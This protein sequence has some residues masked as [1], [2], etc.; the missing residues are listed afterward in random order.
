MISKL[1]TSPMDMMDS[2]EA[3]VN[4]GEAENGAADAVVHVGYLLTGKWEPEQLGDVQDGIFKDTSAEYIEGYR[5]A[6][7]TLHHILIG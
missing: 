7:R 3:C 1:Y 6:W 5:K 4:G 2:Y